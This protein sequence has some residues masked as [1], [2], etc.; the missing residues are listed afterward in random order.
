M[1]TQYQVLV[2]MNCI[3]EE[4][5]MRGVTVEKREGFCLLGIDTVYFDTQLVSFQRNNLFPISG[6]AHICLRDAGSL[7]LQNIATNLPNQTAPTPR[8]K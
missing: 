8:G 2:I 6:R 1:A 4:W 7:F 5:R 3:L